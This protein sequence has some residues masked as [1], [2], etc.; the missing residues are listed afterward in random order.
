MCCK[1]NSD[2]CFG[3]GQHDGACTGVEQIFNRLNGQAMRTLQ[4]VGFDAGDGRQHQ[5]I[6]IGAAADQIVQP[7]R[8]KA[9]LEKAGHDGA[10]SANQADLAAGDAA[11]GQQVADRIGLLHGGALVAE[12]AA[13]ADGRIDIETVH[14]AFSAKAAP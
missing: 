4:V 1:F 11:F 12:F 6:L 9:L 7:V 13:S 10:F 3:A 5:F 14:R 2:R 8:R